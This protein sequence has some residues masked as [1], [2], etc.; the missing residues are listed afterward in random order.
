MKVMVHV[1]QKSM[2]LVLFVVH[3]WKRSSREC[4]AEQRQKVHDKNVVTD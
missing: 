1:G 2:M 4:D 3:R